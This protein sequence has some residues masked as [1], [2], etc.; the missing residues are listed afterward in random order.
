L[1]PVIFHGVGGVAAME[2]QEDGLSDLDRYISKWKD[3]LDNPDSR[4]IT[5][6]NRDTDFDDSKR[7]NPSTPVYSPFISHQS[8]T[9]WD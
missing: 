9:P 4:K 5:P 2:M 8:D 6:F 3:A 1:E 7:L